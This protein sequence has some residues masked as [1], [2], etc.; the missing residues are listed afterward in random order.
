MALGAGL[1]LAAA[2]SVVRSSIAQPTEIPGIAKDEPVLGPLP[3]LASILEAAE[4]RPYLYGLYTWKG[5]YLAH[6]DSVRSVGWKFF[7]L[8]GEADD[9]IARALSE[10]GVLAA[11]SPGLG[12]KPDADPAGNAAYI[13]ETVDRITAFWTRYGTKGTFFQ[14]NP[15]LAHRPFIA[16]EA[17]NEPNF[18][19][20]I[21]PDE[22]PPA[23]QE[24]DR[25]ALFAKLQ[26]ACYA[27]FKAIEPGLIYSGFSAGGAG[28][29]D[30]R[31]VRTVHELNPE[32]ARTYD[33]LGTHPYVDP[34]PPEAYA[35]RSWGRYSIASSLAELREIM[36]AH[37]RTGVP[38]W[39]TEIGWEISRADGGKY[40]R[41]DT[42]SPELQAAYTCRM[43]AYALRLG[44]ERITHMFIT[45]TDG[46][47]G[48]FFNSDG[49]W[50]PSAKAVQH[51]IRLLPQPKLLRALHDGEAGSFA[52][53]LSPSPEK[54]A[55]PV[56][57]AWN[58][59]GPREMTIPVK[60]DR[61]R[62][63]DMLGNEQ[64]VKPVNGNIRIE[65]G[66]LPLY[67][68]ASTADWL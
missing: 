27:A 62:V 55:V 5:E 57:M 56:L 41:K 8:G 59:F 24:K 38:V 33:V 36:A 7:R 16:Q 34:T 48:G 21:K 11:V 46:Y 6:R 14:E 2:D 51:M 43:A 53:L 9:V 13:Q 54:N 50:R 52:Y 42:V 1:A 28:A 45:D 18:Q 30:L 37:G 67:L 4:H 15:A 65:A 39:Y 19:Y 25:F 60:A 10:D 20:L 3:P 23:E 49:S 40:E 31:F 35:V 12:A 47:N 26:P 44:V 68:T 64:E 61:I 29:G 58:V 17:K 63:T 32:I 22:R 66:P